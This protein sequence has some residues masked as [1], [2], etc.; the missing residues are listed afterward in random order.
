[1]GYLS[2][3]ICRL[4]FRVVYNIIFQRLVNFFF[5]K[6]FTFGIYLCLKVGIRVG[7]IYISQL[8]NAVLGRTGLGPAVFGIRQFGFVITK[9]FHRISPSTAT[10]H[11][12]FGFPSVITYFRLAKYLKFQNKKQ[13]PCSRDEFSTALKRN[14][15][16]VVCILPF[17]NF[18]SHSVRA[19]CLFFL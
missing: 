15:M 8:S 4:N 17:T 11:G 10:V 16:V 2:C 5:K 9:V 14:N 12:T 13:C 18:R 3:A 6:I 7:M 1:M 19:T